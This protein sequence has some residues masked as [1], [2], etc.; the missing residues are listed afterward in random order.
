MMLPTEICKPF[1]HCKLRQVATV[2]V[3]VDGEIN[4]N[5]IIAPTGGL[6]FSSGSDS[7]LS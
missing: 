7:I 2:N 1:G 3:V 6:Y 4:G 5:D